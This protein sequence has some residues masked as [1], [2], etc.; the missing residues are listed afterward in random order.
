MD[1]LVYR[2]FPTEIVVNY[3]KHVGSHIA[4]ELKGK[5]MCLLQGMTCKIVT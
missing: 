2:L 5:K 4:D 3:L 1:L